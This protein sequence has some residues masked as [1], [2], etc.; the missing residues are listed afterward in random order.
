[1][2][3]PAGAATVA[4][5]EKVNWPGQRRRTVGMAAH[6]RRRQ[7]TL[8]DVGGREMSRLG[9]EG[10][11]QWLQCFARISNIR[12]WEVKNLMKNG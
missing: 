3:R 5:D 7:P 2:G 12:K 1:M 9:L 10:W 8:K 6:G 4:H 11:I